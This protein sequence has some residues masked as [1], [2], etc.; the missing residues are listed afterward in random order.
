MEKR[1]KRILYIVT[2]IIA[3]LFLMLVVNRILHSKL[4]AD[5]EEEVK[6]DPVTVIKAKNGT[7]RRTLFYTGD[8]H[9]EKEVT[10]YSVVPGKVI[11]YNY[12]EGDSVAKGAA[13]VLL[14]RAETWDEFKPVVV[15][16]PISGVVAINHLDR[17]EFA[18]TQTPLSMVVGG[19]GINVLIK[20]TDI[21]FA[22]IKN[23][24]DAELTVPAL[25]GKFF[26]GKI[27]KVAPVIRRDTRTAPVEIFFE[28][29]D[30]LLMSGM[31]GDIRIII[32]E[33]E[34]A[35]NIPLDTMLFE[36]EGMVGPYCF[37]VEGGKV[38]KK[39]KLETGIIDEGKVEILSGLK[40]GDKVVDLGKES[41]KD[42][43]EI[44]IIEE[45]SEE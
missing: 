42:G 17:G 44:V 21:E 14:E 24:M 45:S 8:L 43:S 7:V 31:F 16:S 10:V 15:E 29:E 25:P 18:T 32:E 33:K 27:S 34:G 19:R 41:L 30:R 37:I 39:R 40:V 23:G 35:I 9:A 5:K 38:A 1:S 26:K 28:N 36:K 12:K 2:A 13:L 11:R 20:V 3:V 4:F 6:K 22:S